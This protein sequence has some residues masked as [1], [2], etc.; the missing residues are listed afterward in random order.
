MECRLNSESYFIMSRLLLFLIVV[1][2]FL[3]GCS[4]KQQSQAPSLPPPET[5]MIKTSPIVSF[6]STAEPG[7]RSKFNDPD[8]GTV[9]IVVDAS[10]TSA[11]G[12]LCKKA[13]IFTSYDCMEVI[14]VCKHENRWVKMPNIWNTCT[15]KGHD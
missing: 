6:I 3:A 7:V 5:A 9:N 2:V 1:A 14:A 11:L 12:E 15:Q 4:N 8:Y 10:Y 13:R